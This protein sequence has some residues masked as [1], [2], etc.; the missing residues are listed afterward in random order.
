L[1]IDGITD[2]NG[3]YG[4]GT[5]NAV[6]LSSL[7][8]TPFTTAGGTDY[9]VPTGYVMSLDGFY[10]TGIG[11]GFLFSVADPTAPY[12]GAAVDVTRSVILPISLA[13]SS[14]TPLF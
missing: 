10:G 4:G 8:P 12:I 9:T 3:G 1:E 2:T 5:V 13:N 11:A 7:M 6:S 14:V